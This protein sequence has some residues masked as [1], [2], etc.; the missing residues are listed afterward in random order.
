MEAEVK[1]AVAAIT[2]PKGNPVPADGNQEENKDKETAEEAKEVK[3][4]FFNSV[5]V[6]FIQNK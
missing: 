2:D 3:R 1:A 6:C 5:S 4:S